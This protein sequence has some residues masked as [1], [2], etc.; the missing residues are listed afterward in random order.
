MG[1]PARQIYDLNG[2]V[3][4]EEPFRNV[5]G[6][7]AGITSLTMIPW[8]T[9]LSMLLARAIF[10]YLQLEQP[11]VSRSGYRRGEK[12]CDQCASA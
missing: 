3:V 11:E 9:I 1:S 7:T 5:N 2:L 12:P 10:I 8:R 4:E 6:Q